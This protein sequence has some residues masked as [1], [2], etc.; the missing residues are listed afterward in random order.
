MTKLRLTAQVM[1]D[2]TESSIKLP[3]DT[4]TI[5]DEA[6]YFIFDNNKGL[7]GS[8]AVVMLS[9]TGKADIVNA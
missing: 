6:D 3:S 2:V 9:A 4:L 5:I 8:G 7:E 1:K